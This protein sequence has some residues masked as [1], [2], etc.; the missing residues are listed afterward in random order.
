[1]IIVDCI[2]DPSSR[3][4]IFKRYT[5]QKFVLDENFTVGRLKRE[6]WMLQR[7]E[8]FIAVFNIND[9]GLSEL[10]TEQEK[11]YQDD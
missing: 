9:I 2:Y 5:F 4:A 11:Y 7:S 10:R 1:L 3:R 6:R 8:K